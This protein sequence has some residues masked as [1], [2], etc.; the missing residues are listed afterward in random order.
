MS[1]L[2][3]GGYTRVTYLNGFA[4]LLGIGC[5]TAASPR[6]LLRQQMRKYIPM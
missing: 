3:E 2:I 6:R 1:K 5:H 4:K